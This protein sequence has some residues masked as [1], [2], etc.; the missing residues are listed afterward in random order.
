LAALVTLRDP[1]TFPKVKVETVTDLEKVAA[2]KP[3]YAHLCRTTGNRLPFNL[4]E[5]HVI[6]CRHF[7]NCDPRI[8]EQPLFYILRN[9]RG[10]CVAI[11]PFILSRRRLGPLKIVSV[12]LMGA[13]P[14]ITEIR[15]PMVAAGYEHL[16]AHAVRDALSKVRD[17][18]WI[19]WSGL[20]GAFAEAL[21]ADKAL[22]WQ[23]PLSD[24]VLDLPRSWEEFRS[25]LKRNIRE[26]LRHCYNSLKRD[27]LEF[28]FEVIE[29][30]EAVRR[31]LTQFLKLHRKRASLTHTVIH[32]DRF[33][34]QVSRD[35]LYAVCD[36]LAARGSV[37]LFALKIG[38]QTVAMRLGFAVG[39]AL[40]LY[41][42]GFDPEWWR[43]GVMTTTVAE[44]IKYA[45]ANGFRVVNLSPAND[46]SKSRWGPRQI[47]YGSAYEPRERL[48]SRW[49]NSAYLMARSDRSYSSK[50]LH[51]FITPHSWN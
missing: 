49:A 22:Q 42:S 26:S 6:W 10:S 34:S 38:A 14:A 39:D 48:R 5:W 28:E 29:Q 24:F 13:D 21:T 44:A 33:A 27:G 11:L 41:Y 8:H 7:L 46:V 3:E 18:D 1:P 2:L 4:H 43:Y 9:M 25:G 30:P 47:D 40:Y 20:G 35:F 15:T 17:W 51:R 32:P 36:R 12:S 45:I 50:L 31:G 19:H 37:R 16:A 23:A